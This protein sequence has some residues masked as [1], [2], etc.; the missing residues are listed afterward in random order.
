MRRRTFLSALAAATGGSAAGIEL[1]GQT[2]AASGQIPELE[3]YSTSSL[4]N[5]N[6]NPLTNDA[7]VAV[8][9]EDS[10]YNYDD[11]GNGDAVSYP[12]ST[13]IPVVASDSNVVGF[14]SMLVTD[15]DT[16]WQKGNEEFVLNVWDDAL[17]GSGTVLYDEG[18][19]QYNTL[20]DFSKFESYAEN[21]GYTVN[22]TTSLASDLSGADAAVITSPS[23]AFTNSE[24]KSLA[25]FVSNGGYLFLH[26][27]ADYGNYDETQNLND[28]ASYLNLAFRFNDDQVADDVRNAGSSY[29]I[30]TTQF[31]TS[32]SYFGDREGLGLDPNKTYTVSV[33]EVIDGD[34]V[35]VTF[36][37]GTTE[38]IRILG[39]DTAEKSAN[40]QYER[41][42][43]WEG[44]ESNTYLENRAAE[45]TTFGQNELGGK[46]VDLVFDDNEPVRD[47]FGRVLGYLYYDK[48]GDG[49]RNANYNHQ[50]VKQGHARVYDSSFSK[51]SAFRDSEET[52]RSNGTQ[53]W[54]QSDPTK[55]SEIRDNPVDDLFFPKAAS[56]RTSSG[57][58]ADSRVPVY[59]E[60]S[61][62]QYLDGGYSYSGDIPLVAVDE[63]ANV[64]VVGG[65]FIDEG[66][67]KNE[68][69]S[70]DTSTYENYPFLT[71]LVDY[72][73]DTSGDIL[74]D[75]GHGQ[76][77]ASYGLSAED[78]AYYMRYLEGQDIGFEGINTFSS[79]NLD[80]ARAVIVTTP[81][82]SFTSTE[83]D[84]LNTFVSNGGAVILMG[85]GETSA[86]ARANINSLANGLGTDLRVNADQVMDSTNSVASSQ[87]VFDTTVLDT[88]FPLFDAYTPDSG[89]SDYSVSIP[90]IN[91]DGSTLND[92]YVDI[93]NDGSSSLDMTGWLLEDEAGNDYQFPDGFSLGA[94][95]TVRVHSGSGT[96]SSTDLYWGGSYIWNND[97][98]TAYLYDSSG[99]T[100]VTKSYPNDGGST[101]SQI[102]V[103][104]LSEDGS[105]LNGEYVDFENTGSSSQDMTG[106]VVE[107]E[108]GNSYQFPD[109]FTL[110]AG[111]T[112]RLHSGD[113]TDSSTDLY[114]GGSYIWNNGGDTCYL[115]DASGSLH[116]QYSY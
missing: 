72:L 1:T 105:T 53:V 31:N 99:A 27:Q 26:D 17:G 12:D 95:E 103:K 113:G 67:E 16:N 49:T 34:T 47:V 83:I 104:N 24:L 63:D 20:A 37:D 52:A 111:A 15:S 23:T 18:H 40:S 116:T 39:T 30:L 44:I 108:A 107:D 64:G 35:K 92:E 69:Y 77:G 51:H 76:F 75:G 74:I 80:G 84:N 2:R 82:E 100:A 32:F 97:S 3:A 7:Y 58:V 4:L 50:L 14:G 90:N 91:P 86:D 61:A 38:N 85:S 29:Q 62:T 89:S 94:G 109:N 25:D 19:S 28:I 45:A 8:W 11:D 48:S 81:P 98:D 57:G 5:A 41:I 115:Y 78:A 21:N 65:P 70:T 93:R 87:E 6:K 114:W 42:Q 55:S 43:E 112:V 101:D 66:Y 54:A 60:T 79:A 110:D 46:T 73:A 56:V 36:D 88:S 13:P 102:A 68:G 10:A 9:A 59:A 96:D 22:A 33:K 71:N 106:W